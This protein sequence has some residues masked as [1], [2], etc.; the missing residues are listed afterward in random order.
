[1]ISDKALGTFVNDLF[2]HGIIMAKDERLGDDGERL[3]NYVFENESGETFYI[4]EEIINRKNGQ[5]HI[6]VPS[7]KNDFKYVPLTDKE[8]CEQWLHLIVKHFKKE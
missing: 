8:F 6:F 4:A 5:S 1:M 7:G 2:R 3:E